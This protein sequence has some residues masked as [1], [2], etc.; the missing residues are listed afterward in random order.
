MSDFTLQRR[1]IIAGLAV[2]LLVDGAFAYYS[3]KLSGVRRD[4][5]E[6]LA[7]E[8]TQLELLRADVKRAAG[9][10]KKIPDY[11][12]A[13]D[14]YEG[15]LPLASGGYSVID[16]ELSSVA[17]ASHV[18][19]EDRRFHQKDV[20][21]R[22]LLEIGLDAT[23]S[24][25]YANIVRFLNALQRSRNTYIVDSLGLESESTTQGAGAGAPAGLKV[26]LHLRTFFR[27]G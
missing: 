7:A 23:V 8:K 17:K 19:L 9:I 4:P 24:G 20:P 10:Q 1:L 16:G 27:K 12:K 18:I 13:F 11:V 2:L 26:N 25:E 21:G 6:I 3:I 22:D 5:R 14:K 15:D